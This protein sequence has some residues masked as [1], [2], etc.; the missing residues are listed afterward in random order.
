LTGFL[1][2]AGLVVVLAIVFGDGAEPAAAPPA[3]TTV[4]TTTIAVVDTTDGGMPP[5]TT[6]STVTTTTFA[7]T[8]I[9]PLE[10]FTAA[11]IQA[12]ITPRVAFVTTF[13]GSGS[14]V[15]VAEDILVT[16]AHV[17]WPFTTVGVL[18][19]GDSRRAGRVVGIDPRADLA[20]IQ[21]ESP[22]LPQPVPLGSSTELADG[23]VLYVVG[24]PAAA[25]FAP[26]P[27]I[28]V[29]PFRAV[30]DWEFSGAAW[31]HSGSP[32]IGGQ[33]GGALVDEYGRLVG[34]T[35]FGSPSDLYSLSVEDVV[36]RLSTLEADGLTSIDER[37]PPRLGGRRSLELAFEG[38]WEQ[39][40]F[41][42]W[43]S[44]G[45]RSELTSDRSVDWR[46]LDPFGIELDA[47]SGALD[48]FWGLAT[49]GVVLA[50]A[51]GP[52]ATSVEVSRPLVALDDPDDA[53]LLAPGLGLTGFVDVPGDRDW[54]YLEVSE[55]GSAAVIEVEAQ[56]RV[57]ITLFDRSTGSIVAEVE[58]ERGFFFEDPALVVEGLAPGS[59]VVTVEDVGAQ[60]G[61]YRISV[62]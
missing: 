54:Y 36:A 9:A 21:V 7:Q 28:D 5:T 53:R 34:V 12:A 60:F 55:A 52:A 48:V 23:D 19:P 3:T 17:I 41:V 58:H 1:I 6:M 43:L 16:N 51:R 18:F 8:A 24:Y 44:P 25:D 4:T 59:Y 50:E 37:R 42:T 15:L 61:T 11:D 26:D 40:A 38:P 29:G 27:T 35:T 45:A 46:A 20:F 2:A 62:G 30:R 57:R 47:G 56:T 22:R 39:A 10:L 13:N 31:V 49:P 14:G 33:S 32:A